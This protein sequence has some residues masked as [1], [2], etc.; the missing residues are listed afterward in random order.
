MPPGISPIVVRLLCFVLFFIILIIII[1]NPI[2]I[3][4]FRLTKN[5]RKLQRKAIIFVLFFAA[6]SESNIAHF[7]DFHRI[8]GVVFRTSLYGEVNKYLL[9]TTAKQILDNISSL[10]IDLVY[11]QRRS[12][13]T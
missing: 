2:N 12:C 6:L 3:R 11:G 13:C 1:N 8:Y 7:A 4:A 10:I 9:D 5:S